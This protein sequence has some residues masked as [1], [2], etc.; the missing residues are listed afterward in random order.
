MRLIITTLLLG[1]LLAQP[2]LAAALPSESQLKQELKQAESNKNAANQAET[3]EALQSALNRLAERTE[4]LTRTE[5]YQKVIDDFPK[6]AQQLRRQLAVESAKILPNGDN[7]PTS[8]LEQQILQ[9]SSQ[10]LEQA[11]LMQQEQDRSREISDSLG[12]LPQQ[13]T[14]ARRTLTETQRRLQALPPNPTKP[15]ALAQLYLLQTEAAARKAKVNELDLAQLSANNRQELARM[16]A[17][18]FKKRHEKLDVQ[19]QALRNNLNNQR[20]REAELALKKPN[21]WPNRAANCRKASANSC[22]L[23]ANSPPR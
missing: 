11:R 9:T 8:E 10:L 12:Q 4:S 15:Q 21:S 16:R 17:E 6:M 13:Q 1:C 14:E 22:K 23:T 7:L 20:Q 19:L 2:A 5:Q 18:V 3:V